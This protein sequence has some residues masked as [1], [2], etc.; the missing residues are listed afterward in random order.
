MVPDPTPLL[1]FFEKVGLLFKRRTT[2]VLVRYS[3]IEAPILW[4]LLPSWTESHISIDLITVLVI[5]I[6]LITVLV[7]HID[8]IT[9]FVIL[10][11]SITVCII[12]I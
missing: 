10:I 1:L 3:N 7:L 9:V 8:L 6:D 12:H 4:Q 5:H 11:D 2:E